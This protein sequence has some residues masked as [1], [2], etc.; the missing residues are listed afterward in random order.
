MREKG[1]DTLLICCPANIHYLTGFDGWGYYMQQ[2]VIM[3]ASPATPDEAYPI[4]IARG[5]DAAAGAFCTYLPLNRVYGYADYYV[6]DLD[7]HAVQLAM[8]LIIGEGW[9]EGVIS[10]DMGADYCTARTLMEVPLPC[11]RN[12]QLCLYL[13]SLISF[14]FD[15]TS[16]LP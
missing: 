8:R 10:L 3:R 9:G 7:K 11:V 4:V 14:S 13:T 5:M 12:C 15:P 1:I 2:Y 6:D 16:H